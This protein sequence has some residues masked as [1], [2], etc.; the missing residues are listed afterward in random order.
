M[1]PVTFFAGSANNSRRCLDATILNDDI[2]ERAEIFTVAL[3]ELDEGVM[4]GN[5]QTVIEITDEEGTVTKKN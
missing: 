5:S 2:A 4:L 1:A 3:V